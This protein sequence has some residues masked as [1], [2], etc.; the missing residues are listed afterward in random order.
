M[1][2][3]LHKIIKNL[4]KSYSPTNINTISIFDSFIKELLSY[5][6][7][8]AHTI[9]D[10]NRQLKRNKNKGPLFELF[11]KKY[12]Q[13]ILKCDDIWLLK[14]CPSEI[15]SELSMTKKDFGIDLIL[16]N[17]NKYYPIQCKFK[18]P[19]KMS[20]NK[21]QKFHYMNVTWREL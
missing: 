13:K 21:E 8:S 11:C 7:E 12:F 6:E 2:D 14:E 17:G 10:L 19:K 4:I 15:L 18:Q 20:R 3:A 1:E 9:T 16:R 5:R